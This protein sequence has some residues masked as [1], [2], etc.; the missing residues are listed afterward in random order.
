MLREWK[1]HIPYKSR[2]TSNGRN[3]KV[4]SSFMSI[5]YREQLTGCLKLMIYRL[6]SI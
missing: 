1:R 2:V 3:S 4:K 5:N 6:F